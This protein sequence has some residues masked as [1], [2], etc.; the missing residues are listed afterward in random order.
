MKRV[1]QSIF[2]FLVCS[3]VLVHSQVLYAADRIALV[4]G[5]SDYQDINP[6]PNPR[7]D[8]ADIAEALVALGF[9][10]HAGKVHYDLGERALRS[11]AARFSREA[12]RAEIAFLFFA[13]HGMQFDGDPHLLPVDVPDGELT[14]VKNDAIGLNDLLAGLAGQAR[15]TIA[16]IDACREIP[17]YETQIRRLTRGGSDSAWRGLSRPSIKS[18]STLIAYSGGSGELVADGDGRNSPYT[19][20][21]LAHLAEDKIRQSRLDVPGLFAEVSYQFRLKHEGQEPEVINQGVRPNWHYLADISPF[22]AGA[23][24]QGPVVNHVT[25]E[26]PLAGLIQTFSAAVTDD[27]AV[28]QVVLHYKIDDGLWQQATMSGRGSKAVT[29]MATVD[30]GEARKRIY[31]Y[32]SARDTSGN[33]TQRG[34]RAR[35]L[36]RYLAGRPATQS[37]EPQDAEPAS[38]PQDAKSPNYTRILLGVVAA[39]VVI[40]LAAGGGGDEDAEPGDTFNINVPQLP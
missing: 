13:G 21:L 39:G 10:L 23:D 8:A 22:A 31:Y 15:L 7:N 14:V 40:A 20:V 19:E 24:V 16:V 29:Y 34:D 12:A 1:C 38:L 11:V 28:E 5:N 32:I 30:V 6:L 17:K 9:E 25:S 26:Q 36:Q 27:V 3:A 4:V 2:V 37:A 18:D 33:I 35:P